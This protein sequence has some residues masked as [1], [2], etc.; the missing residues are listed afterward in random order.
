MKGGQTHL[1]S[2]AD[3]HSPLWQRKELSY[4][5]LSNLV[6]S[7]MLHKLLGSNLLQAPQLRNKILVPTVGLGLSILRTLCRLPDLLFATGHGSAELS[8]APSPGVDVSIGNR[9]QI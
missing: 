7:P 5:Y 4:I 1:S 3:E 6:L 9:C 8:T 2:K